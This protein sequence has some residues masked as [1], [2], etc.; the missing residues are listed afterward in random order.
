MG[1]SGDLALILLAPRQ[2]QV[3]EARPEPSRLCTL[4]VAKLLQHWPTQ[5]C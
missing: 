2:G 1:A 4:S 3:R 5:G